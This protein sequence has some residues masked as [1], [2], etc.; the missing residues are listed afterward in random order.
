MAGLMDQHTDDDWNQWAR[1]LAD[2]RSWWQRRD[3]FRAR[4]A[5]TSAVWF[6]AGFATALVV[7]AL[8]LAVLIPS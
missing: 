3:P 6:G 2:D 1:E 8:L 7:L 5:T 4:R